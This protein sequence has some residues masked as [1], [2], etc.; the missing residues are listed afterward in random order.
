VIRSV[1][2]QVGAGMAL[3]IPAA[4][5]AA[6]AAGGLLFGVIPTAANIYIV[7][8]IVLIGIAGLAA[9]IPAWRACATDP[10]EVLR[11]E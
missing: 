3:G 7:A 5:M 8:A 2:I 1:V 9:W 4:L 6:R 11:C 10:S